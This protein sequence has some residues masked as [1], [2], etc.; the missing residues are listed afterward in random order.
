MKRVGMMAGVIAGAWLAMGSIAEA[1][2]ISS[3]IMGN[4]RGCTDDAC[5]N[6]TLVVDGPTSTGITGMLD[7]NS[8]TL[9][10]EF[11]ITLSSAVF[12]PA[13]SLGGADNGVTSLTFSSVRYVGGG[14]LMFLASTQTWFLT[15][16]SADINGTAT[17]TGAGS[18]TLIDVTTS[19]SGSCARSNGNTTC[20]ITFSP[21]NFPVQVNGATRYF[22]N[23][24][25]VTAPEPAAGAL[26]GLG[27]VALAAFR[28]RTRS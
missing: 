4:G 5:A 25:N 15:S 18:A 1:A 7:L 17:P 8:V 19:I 24:L 12:N 21:R 27:L 6:V 23:T 10:L 11:D 28:T 9:R 14:N 16:G 2:F 13:P 22:S 3:G 26:L 20:G